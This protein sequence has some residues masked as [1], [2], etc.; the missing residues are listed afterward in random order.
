MKKVSSKD[1]QFSLI[2][3]YLKLIKYSR[4]NILC[5]IPKIHNDIKIHYQDEIFLLG[6]NIF[7]ATYNKGSIRMKYLIEIQVNMSVLD[8]LLFQIKDINCVKDKK[9][10]NTINML[11]SLKNIIYGW[12]FNEESKKK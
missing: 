9:I 5:S 11:S 7:Y 12:K 10:N 8:M 6:K 1:E 4:E 3:W 2:N